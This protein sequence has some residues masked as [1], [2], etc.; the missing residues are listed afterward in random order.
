MRHRSHEPELLDGPTHDPAELAHSL[1]Q[2]AQVNRWL[3]GSRALRRHLAPLLD[4]ASPLALLDVGTGNGET[5][6]ETLAW[7]RSRGRTWTGVGV[8]LS[9]QTAAL[10]R[11]KGV[12][13]VLGN[14]LR[15]P[16]ADASFDAVTCTLTLHHFT[17][18]DA[19][20]LVAEMARVS[21][22]VVLVNDLERTR[23]NYLGA[24]LLGLTVWRRNRLTRHDGPRS[25][26]RS[27]TPG[28]LLAI[29]RRAGL[30][31]VSVDRHFPWRVV[32]EGRP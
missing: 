6:L 16:F 30:T 4:A 3:G 22:R 12:A 5:F 27:F 17:D 31:D 8:D 28:E 9:P 26:Q 2:V 20:A 15:L 19:V 10:A 1:G 32:L 24:R 23:A 21:R 29:G 25:V 18:E 13:V 14:A 11:R 7:V